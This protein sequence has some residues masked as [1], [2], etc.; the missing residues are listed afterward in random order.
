M[1]S[2]I[3]QGRWQPLPLEAL[4]SETRQVFGIF[5]LSS[6]EEVGP[7]LGLKPRVI[8]DFLGSRTAKMEGHDAFDVIYL[9]T[10]DYKKRALSA[11]R[12]LMVLRHEQFFVFS[13]QPAALEQLLE[14]RGSEDALTAERMLC[15]LLDELTQRDDRMLS[16]IEQEIASLEDGFM[17]AGHDRY[18]RDI[19][20]L[21]R[22][23]LVLKRYYEQL[24]ALMDALEGNVNEIFTPL[25]LRELTIVS[26]R[27]DRLYK[28]VLT[29]RDYIT[30]VRE[31]YQAQVDISLNQTMRLFTVLTAIFSP[32]TLI[33]G[34]YGMNLNMPETGWRFLYPAVAAASVLISALSIWVFKRRKWF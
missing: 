27:V 23:L 25:A 30:Q 4:S 18:V 32:L 2:Q 3:Q 7:R 9:N 33:T 19:S 29:L 13:S 1:L 11:H 22:T 5:A 31:S 28:N 15:V 26:N 8:Q 34:W 20:G 21:R 17:Q 10:L 14:R 16:G 6:L 12:V 24:C